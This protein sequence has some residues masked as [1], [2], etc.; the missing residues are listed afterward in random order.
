MREVRRCRRCI[1]PV[2][3]SVTGGYLSA[4]PSGICDFCRN[5]EKNLRKCALSREHVDRMIA[6]ARKQAKDFDVLVPVSGGKDSLAVLDYLATHYPG[7]RILAVTLDNGFQNPASLESCRKV[8]KFLRVCHII[9]RPPHIVEMAATFLRQT[10]HLCAPCQVALT[11][12]VNRLTSFH[13]IPLVVLGNSRLYDGAHPEAA[14][15]WSPPFFDEVVKRTPGAQSLREGICDRWLLLSFGLK[16]FLRRVRVL[17]L[18]DYLNWNKEANRRHL[19]EKY[20]IEIG[21]EHADC[22]AHPVADWLYKRRCGFGQKAV[23]LAVM[24]RNGHIAREQALEILAQ[25]DEFG[26]R[27][28]AEEAEPFLRRVGMAPEDVEIFAMRRPDQYFNALFKLV[29]LARKF[30]GLAVA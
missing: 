24:V 4:D 18:P 25:S 10:G 16:V 29:G 13:G 17:L 2:D 30:L 12:I 15:P 14:N 28:P 8:T 20:D 9:W 5:H 19:E 26:E 27:F 23:S 11:N 1:L 22:L 6:W 3:P 21:A 7:L